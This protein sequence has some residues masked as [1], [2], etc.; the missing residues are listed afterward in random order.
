[1]SGDASFNV[2]GI[3]VVQKRSEV[4]ENFRRGRLKFWEYKKLV[5]VVESEKA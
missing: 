1:M 4:V 3:D 2:N 5:K